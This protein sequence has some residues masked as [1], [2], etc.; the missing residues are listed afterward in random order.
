M[1]ARALLAGTLMAL[2]ACAS[3]ARATT[4][5]LAPYQ[6]VRSLQLVQDQIAAGDHAALPMQQR[7]I[8]MIDDRLGQSHPED[9]ADGRNFRALMLYA[10]SG[11][12]PRTVE[13]LTRSLILEEQDAKLS[14]GLLQYV[15]GNPGGAISALTGIEPAN[16]SAD[17][18]PFLALVKGTILAGK[19]PEKSI[20]ML[21]MARL[22]GPGT[23]I[24]EAALRRTLALAIQLKSPDRFLSAAEQ[25]VRRYL[26]S[27]YASHFAD[28]F[29]AGVVELHREIDLPGV[30]EVVSGMTPDQSKVIYL[31][32]ARRAAIDRTHD[33]LA[34]ATAGLEAGAEEAGTDPRADLYRAL[35]EVAAADP[36]AVQQRLG[37]IDRGKLSASDRLLLDAAVA[38]VTDVA[39]PVPVQQP[40]PEPGIAAVEPDVAEA[41]V[42]AGQSVNYDEQPLNEE[43]APAPAVAAAEPAA[44]AGEAPP[45]TELTEEQAYVARTRERLA[46]IDRLL[47]ETSQ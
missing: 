11:G 5:E 43:P 36:A 44:T 13:R 16:V 31:R 34:F 7:I 2:A 40:E 8:K 38:I 9:F 21:D 18:S 47:E 33:L 30:V 10:M 12:N 42:D 14:A 24:E 39:R 23:L 25:Y 46:N 3:G 26:R 22:L 1:R 6:L 20:A 41:A 17:L 28:S 4:D 19:D 32:I 35:A 37:T 45:A 29:V 15:R 27:P